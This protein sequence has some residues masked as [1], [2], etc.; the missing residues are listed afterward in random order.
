MTRSSSRPMTRRPACSGLPRR[1]GRRRSSRGPTAHRARSP[2]AGAAAGRPR[3]AVHDHG[4]DRRPGCRPGGRPGPAGGTRTVLVRGGSH[5]HYVPSGRGSPTRAA[6]EGGHLVYAA[7]GTLRAVAFDLASLTTRGT[8]VPVIPE[9]VTTTTGA[10]DAV[11]AGDGTLAYVSGGGGVVGAGA[12][13][14]LVWV[15]R[16]GH[17]TPIPAPPRAYV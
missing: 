2:L 10:V 3:R 12:P 11:V 17:E 4:A 9:V 15:D 1:V 16:Q 6:R 5:A 14:T 13:R 7:A 8:P